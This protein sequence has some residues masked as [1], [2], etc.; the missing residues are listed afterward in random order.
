MDDG[1]DQLRQQLAE[2]YTLVRELGAGG[3]AVVYLATDLRHGRSVAIRYS[4]PTSRPPSGPIGS[5]AKF[6]FSP[7]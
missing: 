4:V 3:M 7:G 6:A 1:L 2:R 5:C